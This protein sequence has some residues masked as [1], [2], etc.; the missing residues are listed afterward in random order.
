MKEVN[1]IDV[2][3]LASHNGSIL[4]RSTVLVDRTLNIK[5]FP[6]NCEVIMRT[7]TFNLISKAFILCLLNLC[8]WPKNRPR[9]AN[10]DGARECID[11][12]VVWVE[13]FTGLNRPYC[14]AVSFALDTLL[15]EF[16]NTLMTIEC[17]LGLLLVGVIL[18]FRML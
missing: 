10:N 7:N 15:R 1:I 4:E 3:A 2:N 8:V 18:T 14:P 5:S 6:R 9:N 16:P 17:N 12:Q 11:Q 13:D